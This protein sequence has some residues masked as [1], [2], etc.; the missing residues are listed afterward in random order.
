MAPAASRHNTRVRLAGDLLCSIGTATAC[1]AIG[2]KETVAEPKYQNFRL[3][4]GKSGATNFCSSD[5]E[6]FRFGIAADVA[7]VLGKPILNRRGISSSYLLR[8]AK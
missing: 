8:V 1:C 6:D 5:G 7:F 3:P 4:V 2:N